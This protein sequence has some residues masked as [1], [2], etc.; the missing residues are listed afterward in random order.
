M[1]RIYSLEELSHMETLFQGQFDDL[2]F[3]NENTRIWLSRMS[4]EDGEK[5]NNKVTVEVLR[6]GY[7]AAT[8]NGYEKRGERGR[9]EN[10]RWVQSYTYEAK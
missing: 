5:C 9:W 4:V 7:T 3:E 1:K 10:P 2:K 6:G 8:R